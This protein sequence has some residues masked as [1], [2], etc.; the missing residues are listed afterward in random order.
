MK[1]LSYK[2]IKFGIYIH[3]VYL[4]NCGVQFFSILL[5]FVHL[6]CTK[7]YILMSPIV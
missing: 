2:S 5:F 3:K 7:S 1:V 6:S 4:I